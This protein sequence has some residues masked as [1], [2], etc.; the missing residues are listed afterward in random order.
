MAE[1]MAQLRAQGHEDV[2]APQARSAG[3]GVCCGSAAAR[4]PSR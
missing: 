4:S 1:A 2:E 3:S